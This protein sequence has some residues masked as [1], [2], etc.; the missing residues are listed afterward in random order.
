[1]LFEAGRY[2]EAAAAYADLLKGHPDAPALL[3]GLG[4]C[5]GSLGRYEDARIHLERAVRIG[6][7]VP[8]SHYNLAVVYERLGDLNA[9]IGEYR[10]A[11]RYAA[12][13]EPSV[14]ALE[15]LSANAESSGAHPTPGQQL[16]LLMAARAGELARHGDFDG[17][18]QT[19]AEA[20][21]IAPDVALIYQY[22]SNVAYLMGDRKAAM[23]ALERGLKLEPDNA[24]F[25]ENLRRLRNPPGPRP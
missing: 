5:L 6:P 21:R 10:E 1:M 2:E 13:H 15:R 19:L 25:K 9:A 23:A 11:L 4:A 18:M 8:D 17:A 22:R 14:K 16:A 24:L 12:Q 20:E 7:L 3:S